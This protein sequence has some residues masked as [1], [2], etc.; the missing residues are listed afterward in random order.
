MM[1]AASMNQPEACGDPNMISA[2][3]IRPEAKVADRLDGQ[4]GQGGVGFGRDCNAEPK[5]AADCWGDPEVD[6]DDDDPD[7]DEPGQP[8]GQGYG[9][10]GS[11][12]AAER[13]LSGRVAAGADAAAVV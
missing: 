5:P 4:V 7:A 6:P 3:A 11:A 12:L 13:G 8:L 2:G 9:G 10:H 1:V